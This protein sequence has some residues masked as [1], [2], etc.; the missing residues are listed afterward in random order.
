MDGVLALVASTLLHR[1]TALLP[2][3]TRQDLEG[4]STFCN[5]KRV[6]GTRG[7]DGWPMP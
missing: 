5:L 1:Y 2:T 4:T 6:R 3:G 7:P